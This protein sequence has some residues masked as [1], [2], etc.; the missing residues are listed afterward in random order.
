MLSFPFLLWSPTLFI[1]V[2]SGRLSFLGPAGSTQCVL[3][4]LERKVK[5][6]PFLK[7]C[8]MSFFKIIFPFSWLIHLGV[9][10]NDTVPRKKEITAS[11]MSPVQQTWQLPPVCT[12]C[13]LFCFWDILFLWVYGHGHPML[14]R[15]SGW[16]IYSV[17]IYIKNL[18]YIY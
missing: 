12:Q 8:F 9:L 5:E 7:I 4:F 16:D 3:I 15:N 13:P 11:L 17:L 1:A 14:T 2:A 18:L 10:I 6:I